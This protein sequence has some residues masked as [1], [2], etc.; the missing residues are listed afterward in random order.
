LYGLAANEVV[1]G[2]DR[3]PGEAVD[4]VRALARLSEQQRRCIALVD[5]A[6]HAAPSAAA[7]L[8]TTA[9]TVRVQLMRA[10]RRLRTLLADYD[11]EEGVD[12]G[13]HAEVLRS[14][15]TDGKVAR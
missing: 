6:G 9:A 13:L 15:G 11:M 12:T 8:G 10:R 1:G 3:L 14:P 7:I 4:L 2:A 5:V